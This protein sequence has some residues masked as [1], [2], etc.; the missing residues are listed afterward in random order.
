MQHCLQVLQCCE[1]AEGGSGEAGEAVAIQ[2]TAW[3]V[4]AEGW[5]GGS[6]EGGYSVR[7]W[8]KPW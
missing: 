7:R 3:G 1:A 8:S 5:G 4:L 2:R 6:L